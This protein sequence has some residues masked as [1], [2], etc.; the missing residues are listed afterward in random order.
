MEGESR[1][2]RIAPV[3]RAERDRL[4]DR[5]RNITSRIEHAETSAMTLDEVEDEKPI[6]RIILNYILVVMLGVL[7]GVLLIAAVAAV[8][9]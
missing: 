6:N 1:S 5:V 2:E 8:L 9:R 3:S 4:I 7:V